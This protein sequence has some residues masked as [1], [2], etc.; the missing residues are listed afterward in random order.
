L[1]RAP[2]LLRWRLLVGW[3]LVDGTAGR[4]SQAAEPVARL[5]GFD[6]TRI[7]RDEAVQ[8]ANAGVALP[9]LQQGIALFQLR[10]RG[11][12]APG[13]LFQH[14]VVIPGRRLKIALTI[15]DVG[16][17]ELRVP[18]QVSIRVIL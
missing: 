8:L 18:G 3:R 14:L 9:E 2:V 6:R 12:A 7:A 11:L 13:I 1:Y 5:G 17:I 4:H 15:F 10:R 16:Q